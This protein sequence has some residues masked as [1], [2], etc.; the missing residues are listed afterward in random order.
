MK[1]KR[2]S[3][4]IPHIIIDTDNIVSDT[5]IVVGTKDD[6][7]RLRGIVK[8]SGTVIVEKIVVDDVPLNAAINIIEWKFGGTGFDF[9]TVTNFGGKAS[10][11][12]GSL[13]V[14][15]DDVKLTISMKVVDPEE[16]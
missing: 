6:F 2:G 16:P 12:A 8:E 11:V 7:E 15:D 10:V 3:Y 4:N 9:G 5:P 1:I 14:D 13:E